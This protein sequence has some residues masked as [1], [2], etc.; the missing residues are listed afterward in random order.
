MRIVH[1]ISKTNPLAPETAQDRRLHAPQSEPFQR[2]YAFISTKKN[3][4]KNHRKKQ[5]EKRNRTKRNKTKRQFLPLGIKESSKQLIELDIVF[6][7][8]LYEHISAHVS[9]MK[10][11]WVSSATR[12][13]SWKAA[14]LSVLWA[15]TTRHGNGPGSRTISTPV[16]ALTAKL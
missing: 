9:F 13:D 11:T 7:A 1:S 8:E 10:C 6:T 2:S 16:R 14:G 4:R 15:Y 3:N 5:H 12:A